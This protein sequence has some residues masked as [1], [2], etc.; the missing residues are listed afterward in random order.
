M[1]MVEGERK[2]GRKR[3]LG[4]NKGG[5]LNEGSLKEG[6]RGLRYWREVEEGVEEM[7]GG[8]GDRRGRGC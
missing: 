8:M 6:R 7:P 1:R 3:C 4:R 5:S 2:S